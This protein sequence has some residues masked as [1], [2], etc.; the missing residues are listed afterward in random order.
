LT[1]KPSFCYTTKHQ[2]ISKCHDRE[3]YAP[4]DSTERGWLVEIPVEEMQKVALE[5]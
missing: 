3:E 1:T 4:A 5:Q 2:A